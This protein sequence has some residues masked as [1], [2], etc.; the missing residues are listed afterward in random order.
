MLHKIIEFQVKFLFIFI[1]IDLMNLDAYVL[2]MVIGQF[3]EMLGFRQDAS[4]L[5]HIPNKAII[6]V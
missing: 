2:K 4:L 1:N 6:C 3:M 5:K